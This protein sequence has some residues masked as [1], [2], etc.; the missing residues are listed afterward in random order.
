MV[1]AEHDSVSVDVADYI[2]EG[3]LATVSSSE[4]RAPVA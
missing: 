3:D 4:Q 2:W 1:P